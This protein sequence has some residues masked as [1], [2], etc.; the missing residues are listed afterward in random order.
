MA[1]LREGQELMESLRA[2]LE[3]A[4]QGAAPAGAV[5]VR[6]QQLVAKCEALEKENVAL[7]NQVA[8]LERVIVGL[9]AIQHRMTPTISRRATADPLSKTA[10]PSRSSGSLEATRG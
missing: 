2:A 3:Q 7:A 9:R 6:R 10:A 8:T 5:D 4:Q 1:Q